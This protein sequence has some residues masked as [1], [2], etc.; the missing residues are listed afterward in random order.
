MFCCN[1]TKKSFSLVRIFDY[2]TQN[3][4]ICWKT[5]LDD[6]ILATRWSRDGRYLIVGTGGISSEYPLILFD[7][8]RP[9]PLHVRLFDKSESF[10]V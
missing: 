9:R 7:T 1:V 8:S 2:S 4:N 10:F 6:R 3:Q 5:E